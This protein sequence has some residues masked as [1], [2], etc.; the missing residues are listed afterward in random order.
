MDKITNEEVLAKVQKDRQIMK[1]I[2][3]LDI[4]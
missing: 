1:I 4:F 2:T 3:G